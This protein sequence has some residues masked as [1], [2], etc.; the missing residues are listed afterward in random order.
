M[1]KAG[2]KQTEVG[3]IPED[4]ELQTIGQHFEFKNGL[5]KAKE[6]FGHGTPIIN[7]MDVFKNPGVTSSD[8]DG[9]VA[10]TRDEINSCSAKVGDVFFTRTSET[11]DEIGLSTVLLEEVK[12]AVFSGFVL[13][14]REKGNDFNLDFKKYCFRSEPA[15]KQ[16]RATS[17]YTTRALTN[18]K[19]LSQVLLAYPN[20]IDE[21]KAI[22]DAL[23]DADALIGS[24]ETLIAKKRNIKTATMQQLLTGK[25]RL[26]GFGEGKGTKQTEVGEIPEDWDVAALGSLGDFKNG[27]NKSSEE[28][29]FGYPM[30][31]LMHVFSASYLSDE[32]ELDL[33]NSSELDRKNYNLKAGDVLFI[34]SSVKPSG[35]G[36]TAVVEHDLN[37]TVFSGF[38]VRFRDNGELNK[39][40]KRHCFYEENFRRRVI[41]ASSVSANTN[42]NQISLGLIKL[43]FPSNPEEQIEISKC[44]DSIDREIGSLESLINKSRAIKQGMMQELLTG[45]TRLV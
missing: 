22:A 15:R 5:N 40:F 32:V 7:Y 13:R 9:K 45:R 4:W 14:A 8:I 41:A 19:L 31:N 42:I 33:I 18:G 29:G 1:V 26:P 11:V 21:Q 12:G 38:L 39:D 6:F 24:L 27:I 23:S 25:K 16:I 35:V 44:L 28:F 36:L 20:N 37:D 17:S 43:A 3:E 30:V 10:V 34:R 2:Y